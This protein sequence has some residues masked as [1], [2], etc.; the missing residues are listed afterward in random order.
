MENDQTV[1]D[2]GE[3]A[4]EFAKK[5]CFIGGS[6][7]SGTTLLVSLL[8]GHPRLLPF[9]E[10]TAYLP[11]TR[12]KYLHAGRPAQM[13]HLME[14]AESRLLFAEKPL[15]GNRDYSEFPRE[16]FRRL[17]SAT[18]MDPA[19]ASCD[20]LAL[21]M[22]CYARVLQR[23][24][25]EIS[26]WIE[27]TP[28]NRYCLDDLRAT[29]PSAKIILTMRDPR[30]VLAAYLLRKRRQKLTFSFYDCVRNWRQSA[31]AALIH[32]Q[33]ADHFLV[34]K[35]ED[36]LSRPEP[37]M[38][39]V[40][41]FLGVDFVESALIPTKA[42]RSW[43]GNAAGNERFDKVDTTPAERWRTVLQEP[44]IAWV[45]HFCREGMRK[46]G[47]EPVTSLSGPGAWLRKFPEE[48]W[49]DYVKGRRHALRDI[50]QGQWKLP[51]SRRNQP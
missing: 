39:G 38:Q 40:C 35:F 12:R 19:N 11:T 37:V 20:L 36:L 22:V 24:L 10:E 28:A 47:Y 15:P 43:R 18:A 32:G 31:H 23:P 48:S 2:C 17:F 1:R 6:P 42:G 34:V 30:A 4:P 5:A 29:F 3:A 7:K 46:F 33:D 8:D 14:M 41:R 25:D 13:R 50:W 44:E 51:D 45:E 16:A 21:M 9:P 49:N 27:K 26:R